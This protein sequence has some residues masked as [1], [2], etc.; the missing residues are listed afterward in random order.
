MIIDVA[1]PVRTDGVHR[2]IS[3][4]PCPNFVATAAGDFRQV[5]FTQGADGNPV[6][7]FHLRHKGAV[8]H[9][10]ERCCLALS[11][12]QLPGDF[13]IGLLARTSRL[14]RRIASRN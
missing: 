10:I 9:C 5:R 13:K 4:D 12:R 7:G 3:G 2:C 8:P 1:L 6:T 11:P 14:D